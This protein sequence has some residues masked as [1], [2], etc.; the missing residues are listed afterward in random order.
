MLD[1]DI[2]YYYKHLVLEKIEILE[3]SMSKNE[4]YFVGLYSLAL[5]HVPTRYTRFKVDMSF[6]L[7]KSERQKWK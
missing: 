5:N 7:H 6:Y 3:L 1:D 2:H 4:Y